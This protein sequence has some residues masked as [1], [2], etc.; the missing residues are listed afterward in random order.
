MYGKDRYV[1][2]NLW[3]RLSSYNL[4][5]TL[6]FTDLALCQMQCYYYSYYHHH[7]HTLAWPLRMPSC[8]V[9]QLAVLSADLLTVLDGDVSLLVA[10][11]PPASVLR[12]WV[13]FPMLLRLISSSG[14]ATLHSNSMLRG[15]AGWWGGDSHDK[16]EGFILLLVLLQNIK[17]YFRKSVRWFINKGSI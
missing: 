17:V 6:L 4:L 1:K 10:V 8:S 15:V 12:V 7:Q 3:K 9:A 16:G 2:K 11:R 5:R 13:L 14:S